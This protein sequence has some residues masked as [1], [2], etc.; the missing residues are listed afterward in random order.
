MRPSK[1]K[2][3][4]A[5]RTKLLL[6][7][8]NAITWMGT[9]YCKKQTDV[10]SINA[11]EEIDSQLKSHEAIHIRQAQSMK[12]SW[13]IF[14]LRYVWDWICNIPLIFINVHAPYKFIA[15]EIEAYLNQND[16]TYSTNGPVYQ[17][18]KFEKLPIGRKYNL[19]KEY[20]KNKGNYTFTNFIKNEII[21]F[22]A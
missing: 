11:S 5:K 8:F 9:I 6:P 3:I 10:N 16:F 15:T 7:S 13:F 22:I 12:D 1:I 2:T 17:W 18:K 14:Y 20:Y 19:A 4:K 21:G